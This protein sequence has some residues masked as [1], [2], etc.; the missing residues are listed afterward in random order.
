MGAS[1][2]IASPLLYESSCLCRWQ[3]NSLGEVGNTPS[4]LPAQGGRKATRPFP[5]HLEILTEMIECISQ[6][7]SVSL[8]LY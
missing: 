1:C 5:M 4:P 8:T 3:S 2:V 6:D 7:M